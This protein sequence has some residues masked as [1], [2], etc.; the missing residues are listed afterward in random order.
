MNRASATGMWWLA[1]EGKP[2]GPYSFQ[3]VLQKLNSGTVSSTTLACP[4]HGPEWKPLAH[5]PEFVDVRQSSSGMS[6][7]TNPHLSLMANWICLYCFLLSPASFLLNWFLTGL[8]GPAFLESSRMFGLELLLLFV[9]S[10]F[11]LVLI[12]AGILG[13]IRLKNHVESGGDIILASFWGGMLFGVVELVL[14]ILLFVMADPADL[15]D[16]SDSLS[17]REL[18][19]LLLQLVWGILEFAFLIAAMVWL[20]RSRAS[21]FAS[22]SS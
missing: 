1:S 11:S 6:L 22:M 10:A 15:A 14:W 4:V 12:G 18:V 5:W 21:R 19:L 9:S 13:A 3:A 2:T 16:T 8:A 17:G 20:H 7:L